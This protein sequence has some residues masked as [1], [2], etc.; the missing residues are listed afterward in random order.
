MG[1]EFDQIQNIILIYRTWKNFSNENLY[2]Y[3]ITSQQSLEN[4]KKVYGQA[5]VISLLKMPAQDRM[6]VSNCTEITP[7][8]LNLLRSRLV[9]LWNHSHI[10]IKNTDVKFI[11]TRLISGITFIEYAQGQK[12]SK[13]NKLT[14]L[15]EQKTK[16][17]KQD[18]LIRLRSPTP[19]GGEP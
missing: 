2:L 15:W 14:S 13:S 18:S 11:A 19:N 3:R 17:P 1:K 7:Q 16:E 10:V 12:I 5:K 9:M 6:V 8:M 4:M